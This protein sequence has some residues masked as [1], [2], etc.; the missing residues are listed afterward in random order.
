MLLY[1]K[2]VAEKNQSDKEQIDAQS[3]GRMLLNGMPG[4]FHAFTPVN[5]IENYHGTFLHFRQQLLKIM[6][7]GFQPVVAIDE[8]DE[9]AGK[10]CTVA[11][12][13]EDC[14]AQIDDDAGHARGNDCDGGEGPKVAKPERERR[15]NCDCREN[16]WR[17]DSAQHP[18][19][20]AVAVNEHRPDRHHR[21]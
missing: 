2:L 14:F 20:S 17:E 1:F 19:G 8:M 4:L 11:H 10:T 12:P 6:Y 13:A 18:P 21:S 5:I 15:D 9:R 16:R 3:Y 7:G